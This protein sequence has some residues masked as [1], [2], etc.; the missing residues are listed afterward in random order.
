MI[1]PNKYKAKIKNSNNWVEGYYFEMPETTYCFVEDGEPNTKYYIVYHTM[2][3]WNLPNDVRMI[4]IDPKTLEE[5][6]ND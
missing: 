4:E 1:K 5:I 2:T 6:K 3:D